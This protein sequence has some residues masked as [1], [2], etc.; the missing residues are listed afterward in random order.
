MASEI[1]KSAHTYQL[2]P[3][4]LSPEAQAKRGWRIAINGEPVEI[5]V[6]SVTMI[7]PH[8]GVSVDYGQGQEG[9]DRPVIRELGGG[10]S[11]T[12]PYMLLNGEIYI[13]LIKE[14]RPTM[15][16]EYIWSVPRGMLN[17]GESHAD[18]A[19]RELAEETGFD[20]NKIRQ[21]RR[22]GHV[23]LLAAGL[24]SNPTY[25]DTTQGGEDETPGIS[26]YAVEVSA[27]DLV[28]TVEDGKTY[29]SFKPSIASEPQ[30]DKATEKIIGSRFVPLREVMQSQDMMT[31]AAAGQLL[32]AFLTGE[33]THPTLTQAYEQEK[34]A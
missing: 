16:D 26:I 33:I 20:A 12:T 21:G 30:T 29:F 9:Y 23:T 11:V 13:G 31:S 28:Q 5:P 34:L 4:D 14:Y 6:E 15:K 22:L 10:G 17:Q 24:N 3:I 19:V 32:S 27:D 7:N 25:F 2:S 8:I 18:A 1:A